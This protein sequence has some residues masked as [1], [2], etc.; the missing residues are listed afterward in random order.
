MFNRMSLA[1]TIDIAK[2]EQVIDSIVFNALRDIEEHIAEINH[3]RQNMVDV[4]L[5]LEPHL[6][7]LVEQSINATLNGNLYTGEDDP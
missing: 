6:R 4:L 2:K 1:N 5:I 7:I 3:N